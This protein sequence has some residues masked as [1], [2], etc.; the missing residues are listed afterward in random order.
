MRVLIGYL[1]PHVRTV[2]TYFRKI[3]PRKQRKR[4][5]Q[6]GRELPIP[7]QGVLSTVLVMGKRAE[8]QNLDRSL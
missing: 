7:S 1:P 2:R 6:G 8:T 3:G 4:R 5:V